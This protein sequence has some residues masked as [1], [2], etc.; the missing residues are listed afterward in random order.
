MLGSIGAVVAGGALAGCSTETEN[1][2]GGDGGSDGGDGGDGG[3]SGTVEA[4]SDVADYLDGANGYDGVQDMTGTEEPTVDVGSGDGF[5]FGPAAIQVSTGTTVVWEWTGQ[6]TP[7]NV[8]HEDG[9]FESELISEE[10]ATFE[11]T[12]EESGTYLYY[13]QPHQQMGMKGAVVVE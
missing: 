3:A 4:P 9:D 1:G 11:Y 5:G 12:F 8:V 10:G 7:H 6:G 2:D 13:C